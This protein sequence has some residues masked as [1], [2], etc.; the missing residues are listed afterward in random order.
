MKNDLDKIWK[1]LEASGTGASGKP[2]D[3]SSLVAVSKTF[4]FKAIEEAYQL[5][6]RDFGENRVQELEEKARKALDHGGMA[7][8]RWHYIGNIQS[9]K[10]KALLRIPNLCSLH[11][12]TSQKI[13]DLLLKEKE[14][15]IRTKSL[16]FFLQVNTSG[17]DE[18][19]GLM[20][21]EELATLVSY[22]FHQSKELAKDKPSPIFLQGLMT[23]G[24]IRTDDFIGDAHKSF[25][26]LSKYQ[27]QLSQQFS[28]E[29][30]Q[31]A[32]LA[33]S[34]G[35]SQDYEIALQYGADLIRVGSQIFGHRTY[36]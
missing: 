18:K 9:N 6:Q 32:H 31:A 12:V 27:K 13:I 36:Y 17:E 33:L 2:R 8:I 22:F 25:A 30:P 4:P 14:E 24:K 20:S 1:S 5:G 29:F 7:D 34:M 23:I 11:S 26:L 3:K 15:D 10:V 28:A 19:S 16:G 21:F 35:M